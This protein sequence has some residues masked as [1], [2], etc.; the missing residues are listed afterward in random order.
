MLKGFDILTDPNK[1]V[2]KETVT[3]G[4]VSIIAILCTLALFWSEYSN[5]ESLR[6]DKN[7]YLDPHP[8]DETVEVSLRIKLFNAPC[9]ILSL[10]LLDDLRHHRIDVSIGKSKLSSAGVITG[11]VSL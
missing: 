5:F 3:G 4:I 6:V 7:L 1:Q 9:G 10:D 8:T 11:D 2:R